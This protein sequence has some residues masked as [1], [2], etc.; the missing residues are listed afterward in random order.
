MVGGVTNASRGTPGTSLLGGEP[1]RGT[2]L[3]GGPEG[4]QGVSQGG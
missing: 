3:R 1:R 2:A 4:R